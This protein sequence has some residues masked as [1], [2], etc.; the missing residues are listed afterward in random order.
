MNENV[1]KQ[2]LAGY[3]TGI[4]SQKRIL[5]PQLKSMADNLCILERSKSNNEDCGLKGRS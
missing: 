3:Q 2:Q 4:K 5:V 1:L